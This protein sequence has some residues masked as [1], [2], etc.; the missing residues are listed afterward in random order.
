LSD[1][2]DEI[3]RLQ[4]VNLITRKAITMATVTLNVR[5]YK[6]DNN[7]EY[8]DINP[9]ITAGIPGTPEK[10]TLD[11]T[12]RENN[13]GVF[14]PVVGK[15]RRMQLHEID[16]EYLRNGWLPDTVEHG[17]INTYTES[18]TS[19]SNTTWTADQVRRPFRYLSASLVYKPTT[20]PIQ[21][22]GF[23]EINGERRHVRHINFIG[24]QSENIQ[25]RLVYDCEL[26]LLNESHDESTNNDVQMRHLKQ[27]CLCLTTNA[28]YL[29]PFLES[30]W[31]YISFVTYT[32]ARAR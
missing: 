21:T 11:W 1:D 3:L 10:R 8:I 28:R 4:G 7:V 2:T 12:P 26:V 23:E 16:N 13:D 29:W 20:L 19:K 32:V 14:G 5:H 27:A 17:A 15:S 18:D 24:P 30:A 9:T 22:W 31:T 25:A 6:G